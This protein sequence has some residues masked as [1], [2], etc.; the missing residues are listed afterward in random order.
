MRSRRHA[1]TA[2][3]VFL[4]LGFGSTS[5]AITTSYTVGQVTNTVCGLACTVTFG[6]NGVNND[7]FASLSLPAGTLNGVNY[8]YEGGALYNYNG[9][10]TTFPGGVS[11]RPVGSDGNYWSIG[12]KPVE[13]RGPGVVTFETGVSYYGFLWGSPDAYN[14]VDF[15]N[16]DKLLGSFDGSAVLKPPNG[17]QTYSAYYDVF[18]DA[19]ESITKVEF[20]SDRN[21]FETDNHA[22]MTSPAPEPEIYAMI[23]VGLGV[24]GWAARKKK[25][26]LLPH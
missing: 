26:T 21:A 23:A 11:A 7:S 3:V 19:G 13:Q 10:T 17:D 24:M 2:G 14:K 6:D 12:I 16:G 15:Y 1:F 22:F 20:Y 8:K 4:G 18:A 5:H 25:R 9:Q